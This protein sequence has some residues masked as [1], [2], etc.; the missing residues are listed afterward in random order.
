MRSEE[1]FVGQSIRAL[2]TMLRVVARSDGAL[3][4]VVPDGIYGASTTRAV[5]AFQRKSGKR[6]TGSADPETWDAIVRAYGPAR[7]QVSPAEHIL[8]VMQPREV[9]SPGEGHPIIPLAQS[10]LYTLHLA[11]HSITPPGSGY[12]LD[13]PTEESLR[14]FQMLCG[15]PATG[16]LDR[17]SWYLLAQHYP[18]AA[19]M[20]IYSKR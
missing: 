10:I 4:S 20:L 7:I 18:L 14:S 9:V 1:K 19:K 2:Q 8:P 3:P 16:R 5:S 6:V 13:L 15:I 17:M 12:V 11:L